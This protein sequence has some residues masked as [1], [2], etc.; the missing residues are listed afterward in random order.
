MTT[1]ICWPH[2]VEDGERLLH[3]VVRVDAELLQQRRLVLEATPGPGPGLPEAGG[4]AWVGD[5]HLAR[6]LSL[7]A[8][9]TAAALSLVISSP[10]GAIVKLLEILALENKEDLDLMDDRNNS[11]FK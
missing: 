1:H 11:I 9:V 3:D 10:T 4:G 8:E 7:L 5:E 2:G 6:V